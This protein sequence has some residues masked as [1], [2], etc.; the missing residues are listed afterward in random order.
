[1]TCEKKNIIKRERGFNY[2]LYIIYKGDAILS[3]NK[4]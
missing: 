2:S 4:K 3:E 1:M